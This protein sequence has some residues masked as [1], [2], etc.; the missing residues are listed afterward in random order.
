MKPTLFTAYTLSVMGLMQPV[1]AETT[2]QTADH[3]SNETQQQHEALVPSILVTSYMET[4]IKGRDVRIE[5]ASPMIEA[6]QVGSEVDAAYLDLRYKGTDEHINYKAIWHSTSTI[7]LTIEDETRP[8][9]YGVLT[10]R[11]G[12]K[13]TKGKSYE[14]AS[15]ERCTSDG[16][17]VYNASFNRPTE[18]VAFIGARTE[19]GDQQLAEHLHTLHFKYRGNTIPANPR[20]ATAG[21]AVQHWEQYLN[22]FG[23]TIDDE[24]ADLAAMKQL[25]PDTPLPHT[26]ICDIPFYPAHNEHLKL[27]LP[28]GNTERYG[29]VYTDAVLCDYTPNSAFL[30]LQNSCLSQGVFRVT[31]GLS[32]PV[33]VDTIESLLSSLEWSLLDF[34]RSNKKAIV[35]W[36]NGE[37]NTTVRDIPVRITLDKET[38]LK[39]ARKIK[40]ED[41]SEV[42]TVQ[43]V[44]LHAETGGY[45]APSLHLY[46]Q[47]NYSPIVDIPQE[48]PLSD[49]T[50]LTPQSPYIYSD[51]HSGQMMRHGLTTLNC[52]YGHIKN[53][54]LNLYKIDSSAGNVARL[55]NAYSSWYDAADNS[56][57]SDEDLQK[58]QKSKTNR[59]NRMRVVPTEFLP[60]VQQHISRKLPDNSGK[61]SINLA[62]EFSHDAGFYFIEMSGESMLNDDNDAP[63]INQGLIQVTDLGLLWKLNG[64]RIFAWGYRLSDGKALAEGRLRMLDLQG[65]ILAETDLRNGT[66]QADFPKDTRYLQLCT[67]DDSVVI[68]HDAGQSEYDANGDWTTRKLDEMGM[69]ANE[70]PQALVYLFADRSIYRPDETAHIKGMVRWICNN[71]VKFPQIESITA[72]ISRHGETISTQQI[73]PEADGSFSLDLTTAGVGAHCV[74]FS[75]KYK[76]DDDNT[77]PDRAAIARYKI[78]PQDWWMSDI[79]ASSRRESIYLMVE[80]FRRN[81][82]ELK[83]DLSA[84]LTTQSVTMSTT[85]TNF[86]TTPVA[87]AHVEWSMDVDV[88]NFYPKDYEDYRFGDFLEDSWAHF[89]AYYLNDDSYSRRS[90][91][92]VCREDKLDAQGQG[93]YTFTLPLEDKL[94]SGPLHITTSAQVTNGNQQT[95]TGTKKLTVHPA[96]AYVGIKTEKRLLKVG[97]NLPINLIAV[98]PDGTAWNGSPLQGNIKVVCKSHKAYRYGS[99]AVSSIQNV[100]DEEVLIEQPVTYTDTPTELLL[101]LNKAGIYTITAECTDNN[102]KTV[103]SKVRHYVWGENES[104]WY[105]RH[106][107]ELTLVEDKPM[108]KAGDTANI[109]VQTPVDAEVLVTV[110]RGDVLRHYKRTITVNNPVIQVPIEAGDAPVIYVGVAM[111]Q[112]AEKRRKSGAPLLKM[113]VC[114]LNVE[115]TDK[116]L[117]V[118]LNAPQEHLLPQDECEVSGIVKDAAGNPVANAEVTLYAEDE[119]TLQVRGYNLPSPEYFFYNQTGRAQ[120]TLTYS[121]L[122]QLISDS[123]NGRYMGNKGVFIGG[124]DDCEAE[125]GD[126]VSEEE[127]NYLRENFNP[128]AIWLSKVQTDAEGR[129]SAKYV[130][131]D[132]MT[133]YRLMAVAATENKFG[134]GKTA[135]HVTKPIMLEPV[136]PLGSAEGDLLHM[137][138]TIS[139]LP[140]QLPEAANGAEVEWKVSLSGSNVVLPEPEKTVRLSGNK[141]ATITFPIITPESGKAELVWSVQ[142]ASP[143]A[144]GTLARCKDAVKLDFNVIPPTPFVRERIC[145]TLQ[146]GQS[147][148][149]QELLTTQYRAGSPVELSISTSPLSNLRYQIQYL[150]TYPYGC[151][152]QL[153]STVMPWILK[154]ELQ[155][156]LGLEYP[157][158]HDADKV[159]S[160][161][162]GKLANRRISDGQYRYW[163]ESDEVSDFSP[164]VVLLNQLANEKGYKHLPNCSDYALLSQYEHLAATALPEDKTVAGELSSLLAANGNSITP[165]NMLSVYV[166]ARSGKMVAD[167]LEPIIDRVRRQKHQDVDT[168]LMLALC[169]RMLKHPQADALK[170][171]ALALKQ[172]K[173]YYNSSQQLPPTETIKLLETIFAAPNSDATAQALREYIDHAD[174]GRYSTWRNAWFTLAVYEYLRVSDAQHKSSLV[175]GQQVN[176]AHPMNV[177]TTT[178]NPQCFTNQGA[179]VYINGY[180]EGHTQQ[181]QANIAIDNGLRVTRRYEKLMPDGTW[182][183]TGTFEVGDIVKVHLTVTSTMGKQQGQMRYL[184]VEDRLPAAFEAVN[185]ALLSQ[186]LPPTV[187]EEQASDWWYYSRNID[188]REYLKDRVRFF[189]TY[190]NGNEM[191]ATYVARVLRRGK[192][193]APAAK[194]ELMYRPE[195][196]GLSIP[197]QFEIK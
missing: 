181:A 193:T 6:T 103:C 47:G 4:F 112:S 121:A 115:A 164:Y 118:E 85:A 27:V 88:N 69:P 168:R 58:L 151:S 165:P 8:L 64:N 71:E 127:A 175:N 53:G 184:A 81:E 169:A 33:N 119:G 94:N 59:L 179:E 49:Y 120:G 129:F 9:N 113:G 144:T 99:A 39:N 187:D 122:G 75:I 15:F 171:E 96:E 45:D 78:D 197:Q 73:T 162:F 155:R 123:L 31:L 138:V 156:G 76:G 90:L 70:L 152:E 100:E 32:V 161:T 137:P 135:Y 51:V 125:G 148:K 95:I 16:I 46:C 19:Q 14:E 196:R 110:E 20:P 68:V 117:T 74:D 176:M 189:S 114:P 97:N 91:T 11:A 105:Y 158:E 36:E 180:A 159:I 149:L 186:A 87:D 89:Y 178:D 106:D 22:Y 28:C 24:D 182:A 194:A 38:T 166:L 7:L 93:Y 134:S 41:G 13:D 101:P 128:C 195:V 37:I 98:K 167:D 77:S 102:G 147:I 84:D 183:P 177:C 170:A 23:Y 43:D 132:T 109:L 63:I 126:A 140:A 18:K 107:T 160:E 67:A 174:I 12:L 146:D 185:P 54:T 34:E 150:L 40:L 44:Y 83:S 26:W 145:R 3:Q 29:S 21:D 163:D 86:T 133:R 62:Q 154:T 104:P 66:A 57:Y 111:V 142:A 50:C 191:Q 72:T 52:E 48:K 124:G 172:P 79:L 17:S 30:S 173:G 141:P 131:P 1:M 143:T 139:M 188:N 130:N 65:N 80:E 60:G 153:S 2:E 10:V 157:Q 61:L 192:V 136:A 42:T 35:Q 25:P 92:Y 5:F 190:F 108:Y 82:F 116:I 56:N 55:L